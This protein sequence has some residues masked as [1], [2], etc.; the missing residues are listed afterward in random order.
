MDRH[1]NCFYSY[2]NDEELIENNLTR[3]LIVTLMGISD[4]TRGLM[5]SSLSGPFKNCN[6]DDAEFALQNYISVNPKFFKHKYL[7]TL[8]ADSMI[9]GM[10][11]YLDIDK[12]FCSIHV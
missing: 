5:L 4:F 9:Q 10:D 3:S 8:A 2:N 7:V 11:E 6:F 12:A 1:L